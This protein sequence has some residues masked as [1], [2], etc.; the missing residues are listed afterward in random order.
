VFLERLTEWLGSKATSYEERNYD[1]RCV[2]DTKTLSDFFAATI[3]VEHIREHRIQSVYVFKYSC[4]AVG[5][6][7]ISYCKHRAR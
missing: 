5:S 6:G 2:N 3:T 7:S 4:S 1:L